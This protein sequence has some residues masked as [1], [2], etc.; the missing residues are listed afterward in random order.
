M[1]R[2]DK[3]VKYLVKWKGREYEGN[4]KEKKTGSLWVK[5]MKENRKN[6]KSM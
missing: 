1:K 2:C 5:K 6:L 4:G 3:H